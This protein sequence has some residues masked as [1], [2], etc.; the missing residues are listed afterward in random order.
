MNNFNTIGSQFE[1]LTSPYLKFVLRE[2][3][4]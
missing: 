3:R 2:T 4:I 1:I